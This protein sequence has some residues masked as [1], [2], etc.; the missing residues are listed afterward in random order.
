MSAT[1]AINALQAAAGQL[2]SIIQNG[3][4]G[5]PD[6]AA[7]QAAIGSINTAIAAVQAIPDPQQAAAAAA[8]SAAQQGAADPTALANCQA[9]LKAQGDTVSTGATVTIAL[10][11]LVVGAI[12]GYALK[13]ITGGS[14]RSNPI[15]RR[16]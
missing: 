11:T 13:T 10:G 7:A 6:A 5:S 3:A 14:M 12:G 8:A 15:R 1:D 2:Q 4:L 16:R 9:Q